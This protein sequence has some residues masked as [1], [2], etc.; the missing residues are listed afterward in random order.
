MSPLKNVSLNLILT[1]FQPAEGSRY[2]EGVEE[3]S[4]EAVAELVEELSKE[5][6]EELE[7]LRL[8]GQMK[9]EL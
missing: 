6:L 1:L 7:V 5:E 3:L 9:E 8:T 2:A 4:E